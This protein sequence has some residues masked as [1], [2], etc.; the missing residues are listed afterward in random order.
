M[1][2]NSYTM[3]G[4]RRDGAPS[5]R[6]WRIATGDGVFW[7]AE[8]GGRSRLIALPMPVGDG[9]NGSLAEDGARAPCEELALMAETEAAG[10]WVRR[11]APGPMHGGEGDCS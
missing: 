7:L 4:S 1:M 9:D 5:P 3:T 2:V 8:D 11:G 10:R 6:V